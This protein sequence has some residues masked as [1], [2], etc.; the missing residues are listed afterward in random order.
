MAFSAFLDTCVLVPSLQRDIL[1]E[2]VCAHL[3]RPLWSDRVEEELGKT[4]EGLLREKG[5]SVDAAQNYICRLLNQMNDS[6]PGALFSQSLDNF[7]SDLLSHNPAVMG[8]VLNVIAG[9][10]GRKGPVW[11]V[12][13]ILLTIKRETPQFVRDIS[14]Y[15][16]A[17]R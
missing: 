4:L 3:Y 6:L 7:L 17:I 11:S 12:E 14:N 10:S 9:R 13:D 8:H 5:L 1:L 2:A 15:L 16:Q